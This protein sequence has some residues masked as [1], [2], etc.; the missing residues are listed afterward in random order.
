MV[1]R[2]GDV[3]WI[4]VGA[5]VDSGPGGRHPYVVVQNDFF[6]EISINTVIVCALTSNTRRA[7]EYGNV[8][9]E[10]GEA[11]L[12]KRSVVNVSQILTVDKSRLVEKIGSLSKKRTA[13]VIDGI[14]LLIEP[15]KIS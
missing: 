6:N 12:P 10:K 14:N 15:M 5:P 1:I 13:E 9:L 11:K 2:Q 4:N 8:L 3:Y 7:N